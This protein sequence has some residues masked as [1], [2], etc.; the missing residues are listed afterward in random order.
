[1]IMTIVSDR[2]LK[3]ISI[4]LLILPYIL[5]S[6]FYALPIFHS[7]KNVYEYYEIQDVTVSLIESSVHKGYHFKTN[8][9]CIACFWQTTQKSTSYIASIFQH[10]LSCNESISDYKTCPLYIIFSISFLS[11]DPPFMYDC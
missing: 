4:I 5:L 1:M 3:N 10:P 11:R 9:F 2:L 6:A 7:H 8:D